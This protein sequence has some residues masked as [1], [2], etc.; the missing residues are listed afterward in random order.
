MTLLL[1]RV[2]LMLLLVHHVYGIGRRLFL[3]IGGVIRRPLFL[4]RVNIE[5]VRWWPWR[6]RV[7]GRRPLVWRWFSGGKTVLLG[8]NHPIRFR[9]LLKFLVPLWF[10]V[11][12]LLC[13]RRIFIS[14]IRR[15]CVYGKSLEILPRALQDVSE[16]DIHFQQVN[17]AYWIWNE[18]E[19]YLKGMI[20]TFSL[21]SW[22]VFCQW[23]FL[24]IINLSE[25]S[26]DG[27]RLKA[28]IVVLQL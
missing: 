12:P 11:A 4:R 5:R 8:W 6:V 21:N 7:V 3:I 9:W 25:W 17:P 1:M 13:V 28:L 10:I 26:H 27:L 19:N 16:G 23:D 20:I 14:G 24:V 2:L 22:I 18:N 15:A